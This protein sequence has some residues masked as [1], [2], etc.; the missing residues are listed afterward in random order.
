MKNDEEIETEGETVNPGINIEEYK[1]IREE[2]L[3]KAKS[4]KHNWKQKGQ[5][6]I[7]DSCPFPHASFI[8]DKIL[9]GIDENG[10]PILK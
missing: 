3:K 6:L 5:W 9:V 4:V 7:C 1:K 10:L 8:G 2:A